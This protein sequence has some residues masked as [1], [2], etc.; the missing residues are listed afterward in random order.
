M[1]WFNNFAE[2]EKNPNRENRLVLNFRL[3]TEDGGIE[4]GES[5][6]NVKV[7]VKHPVRVPTKFLFQDRVN[8]I[9][10]EI[11]AIPE[12]SEFP[13]RER[14][15]GR[16]SVLEI[17]L[18]ND[19]NLLHRL[20]RQFQIGNYDKLLKYQGFYPERKVTLDKGLEQLF[21]EQD[22]VELDRLEGVKFWDFLT[23]EEALD[24]PYVVIDIEKP[25]WK[26]EKEKRELSLRVKFQKEIKFYERVKSG[27]YSGKRKFSE[28]EIERELKRNEKRKRI[29]SKLEK[30]LT[31][32]VEGV[33]ELGLY[34]PVARADVSYIGT[35][36]KTQEDELIK[37]LYVLDE[38]D[39]ISDKEKNGFTILRFKN[40][41]E[42]V[43]ALR[44]SFKK[45]KPVFS[46]G[47]NQVYD[48]T[49]IDFAFQDYKELFDPAI[50][51][52]HPRRDFVRKFLQR[53][54]EDLIY[55]DTLWTAR[56]FYPFL[57]QRSLGT[58]LKLESLAG[59]LG[60]Q[61]KKSLS[62]EELRFAEL[63][64]VAGKTSEVR[65][66]G[67]DSMLDYSTAD[68]DVTHEIY[69]RMNVLPFL[70]K[71]KRALPFCTLSEIAFATNCMNKMHE[72]RHF[73]RAGNLPY[74]GYDQKERENELQIFK[75][76]FPSIKRDF[77]KWGG[78]EKSEKPKEI[79]EPVQEYYVP[80]ELWLRDFAFKI[81]SELSQVY[82]EVKDNP[83]QNFAF[84]QYLKAVVNPIFTDEYFIRRDERILNFAKDFIG[85]KGEEGK[86]KAQEYFSLIQ[87]RI[88]ESL[89][90]ELVG[91]FRFL[92][93]HFRSIYVT[94]DGKGRGLI[95][96]TKRN[97]QGVEF[98]AIMEQDADLF[99]L[100]EREEGV[101][102]RLS[103]GYQRV[104]NG[105]LTNFSKFDSR[106]ERVGNETSKLVPCNS[107]DLSYAYIYHVRTQEAKRRFFARYGFNGIELIEEMGRKYK[108]LASELKEKNLKFLGNI[109]DYIFV[110]GKSTLSDA[111]KIRD[112]EKFE[113]K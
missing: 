104:L 99:L 98:P 19:W 20:P 5:D 67:R 91:S 63:K 51:G 100:R 105:F 40:E 41:R 1:Y 94:L 36:W 110:N 102:E 109:G 25:L 72:A 22:E 61:F 48:I 81:F 35:I 16:F 24:L 2:F 7:F 13:L 68:L 77:L 3:V 6:R 15:R 108:A 56:N 29:V 107:R 87:S 92:K 14:R 69:Q 80:V 62:H 78:I 58:S 85:L 65:E 103:E 4:G 37:E 33:E 59:F 8:K 74:H 43:V 38:R 83:E 31:I 112:L 90:N 23:E 9:K 71:M 88:P 76:R 12:L 96:T 55:I 28:E 95:R 75:K 106:L 50:P 89:R 10:A 54:K 44:N 39:E 86:R 113:V 64:R 42:L 47:H 53:L 46:I 84:S 52:I 18:P 57:A 66:Q 34:E 32:D 70:L 60:I 27:K 17:E 11:E 73:Q 101:R 93:N 26:K 30:R 111:I 97:L 82:E 49:Q 79:H 21:E 45:R